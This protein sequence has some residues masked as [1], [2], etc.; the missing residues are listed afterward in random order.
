MLKLSDFPIGLCNT[1]YMGLPLNTIHNLQL[2]QNVAVQAVLDVP[3]FVHLIPPL[4]ELYCHLVPFLMQ[5]KVLVITFKALP[6]IGPVYL[7]DHLTN[8]LEK[9]W[10]FSKHWDRAIQILQGFDGTYPEGDRT[11][12]FLR[13]VFVKSVSQW[14][15]NAFSMAQQADF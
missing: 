3:C 1:F 6:G 12:W 7:W 8:K 15:Q 9:S 5:V 2:V 4:C 14:G 11:W 10:L 13:W